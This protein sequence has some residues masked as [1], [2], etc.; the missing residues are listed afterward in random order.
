MENTAIELYGLGY[1][2]DNFYKHAKE[3]LQI[4]KKNYDDYKLQFPN[5]PIPNHLLEEFVLPVA[6]LSMVREIVELQ[7]EIKELKNMFKNEIN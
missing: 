6:L 3:F 4:K 1:L 7:Q 5:E 2:E